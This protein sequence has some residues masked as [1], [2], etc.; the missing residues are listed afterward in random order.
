MSNNYKCGLDIVEFS[1][2]QELIDNSTSDDR[3]QIFRQHELDDVGNSKNRYGQLAA[4]FAAKEACLKLF[5]KETAYASIDFTDFSVRNNEYGALFIS[6][7]LNAIALLNL[8]GFGQI[9]NSSS[10]TQ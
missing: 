9:L 7:S 8:Y 5:P 4:R 10:H 3:K 2:I 6:L 1:R